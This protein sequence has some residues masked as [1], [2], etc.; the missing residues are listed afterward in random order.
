MEVTATCLAEHSHTHMRTHTYQ[1]ATRTPRCC[2]CLAILSHPVGYSLSLSHSQACS[3][4]LTHRVRSKRRSYTSRSGRSSLVFEKVR[5][6]VD[7]CACCVALLTAL[8]SHLALPAGW[9]SS[10]LGRQGNAARH[11]AQHSR[12]IGCAAQLLAVTVHPPAHEV[13]PPTTSEAGS[14]VCEAQKLV[15]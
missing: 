12:V 10:R 3:F 1:H 5:L 2:M 11:S 4:W 9:S 15:R 13:H 7:G 6:L 8:V 14:E